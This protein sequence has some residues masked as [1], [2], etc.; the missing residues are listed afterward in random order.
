MGAAESASCDLRCSS[1]DSSISQ[2]LGEH[3]RDRAEGGSW[4]HFYETATYVHVECKRFYEKVVKVKA[5]VAAILSCLPRAIFGV[6]RADERVSRS[7]AAIGG[8]RKGAKP[9]CG[10]SRQHR[11]VPAP[12]AGAQRASG[13]GGTRPPRLSPGGGNGKGG[14]QSSLL[15]QAALFE[16]SAPLLRALS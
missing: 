4:P 8:S 3:T 14:D 16:L 2:T 12:F 15:P 13:V 11:C 5:D 1:N 6:T 10:G 7:T 9:S